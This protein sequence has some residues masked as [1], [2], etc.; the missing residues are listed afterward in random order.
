MAGKKI[1]IAI[2]GDVTDRGDVRLGALIEQLESFKRA[3]TYAEGHAG[4]GGKKPP[5]QYR[6][7]DLHHSEAAL[8]FEA[9]S[10]DVTDDRTNAVIY[11]FR[12]RLKQI[13]SGGVP[14]DVSIEELEAY[15]ELA[16]KPERRIRRVDVTFDAPTALAKVEKFQMTLEFAQQIAKLIGPEEIAWGTMAGRLEALNLHEKNLFHLYP[17]V[18]PSRVTCTFIR[19]IREDVKRA[20]D[21]YVEVAGKLHYKRRAKFAQRMSEVHSVE[22]LD[23]DSGRP[24]LSELRGIAPDVTGGVDTREFVDTLDEEW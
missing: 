7:V 12:T 18:G 10:E 6:L 20:V 22:M 19:D 1:T 11:E 2:E 3:L 4:V 5:V 14:D 9:F 15:Q 8:T 16:P 24:Q 17:P 21:H 23:T 13:E